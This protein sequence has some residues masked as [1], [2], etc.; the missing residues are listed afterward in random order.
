MEEDG[1]VLEKAIRYIGK[2]FP[3]QFCHQYFAD[4]RMNVSS[5]EGG[6]R[7]LYS[8]TILTQ[9]HLNSRRGRNEL[10]DLV[11]MLFSCRAMVSLLLIRAHSEIIW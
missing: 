9:L 11:R 3:R 4:G 6:G 1:V 10:A 8:A 2:D 7:F 5:G